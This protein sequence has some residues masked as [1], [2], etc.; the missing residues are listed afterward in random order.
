MD[1]VRRI[2]NRMAE[3]F[4]YTHSTCVRFKLFQGISQ[5][6][7]WNYLPTA[8]MSMRCPACI[9]ANVT[10]AFAV[11]TESLTLSMLNPDL[12]LRVEQS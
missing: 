4:I 8:D 10:R 6:S 7:V 12:E 9:L 2:P 1:Y 3:A 5:R 11:G